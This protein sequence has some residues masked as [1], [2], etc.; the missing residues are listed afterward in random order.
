MRISD[1]S[2]K[3]GLPVAT[4]KFYL[5][6]RLIPPGTPTGRNQA[7]YN[8]T[9]LRRLRL[10][11]ALTNIG[12]LDLSSVRELLAAIEDEDLSLPDLYEVVNHRLS[13]EGPEL[14][15][16]EGVKKARVRVDEFIDGLGWH[17]DRDAPGRT[18]LAHV[19]AAMQRLGCE[20][21][22]DFFGPYAEAA[23]RLAIQE[24][25]LLPPDGVGADRAA[26]VARTVLL[27]VALAAMRR[28]AHEHYA[29]LRF[30]QAATA[31]PAR[32]PLPVRPAREALPAREARPA[33]PAPVAPAVR[34]RP[35]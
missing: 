30:G 2:R 26:A 29:T 9:H 5:R 32:E 15:E 10:I 18:R 34:P 35:A 27:E 28:M 22:V 16:A 31:L 33:E 24:L 7:S 11:R 19:L 17:V 6:E 20:C 13:P 25:D 12:K 8:E 4:I 21:G 14:R 23:E 1:L 3:T